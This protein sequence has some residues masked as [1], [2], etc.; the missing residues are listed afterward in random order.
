MSAAG[1]QAQL[2]CRFQEGQRLD[3][4]HG[5]ADFAQGHVVAFRATADVVLDFIGDVRDHL[6]GLAQVLAAAFL[7]DHRFVDLAG[8][9]VVHLFHAGGDEALVVAEVEVGFSAVIGNEDF[10]VLHGAHRA[11]IDVDVR[12]QLEHG[13]FEAARFEDRGEGGGGY[14]FT[15]GRHNATG[16]EDI[17]G[18]CGSVPNGTCG[19]LKL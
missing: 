17:F 7:A 13:D 8:G 6:H 2:A 4:A 11:G 15:K 12:V 16:D 14:P 9:E 3:V 19:K 18:H 1:A 10:T 5:A